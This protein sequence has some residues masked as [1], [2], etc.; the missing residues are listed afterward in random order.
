MR[1]A[2]AAVLTL[3][4]AV[5]AGGSTTQARASLTL[6]SLAPLVV[7]GTNFGA[8]ELVLVTY[9]GPKKARRVLGWPLWRARLAIASGGVCVDTVGT[10][11]KQ[12]LTAVGLPA[13]LAE[14][15]LTEA[16]PDR[17]RISEATHQLVAP[18]V[19]FLPG[20]PRT[21]FLGDLGRQLVWDVAPS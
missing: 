11:R 18:F 5:P 16:E 8:R 21:L 19:S 14:A 4:L 6:D 1:I 9:L 20:G 3:L 7:G 12:D 15:L 13:Q 2:A 10:F 17:L